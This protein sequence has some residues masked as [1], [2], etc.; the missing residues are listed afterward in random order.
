VTP[1]LIPALT[2][3]CLALLVWGTTKPGRVYEF[4]FLTGAVMA[5]W[6]LPQIFGLAGNAFLPVDALAKTVLFM[7]LC[8]GACYFGYVW[9]SKRKFPLDFHYDQAAL[10]RVCAGLTLFGGSFYFAVSRLPE[11]Q[12]AMTQFSGLSVA[13]LF[14][15]D[16]LAYGFAIALLLFFRD[17]SRLALALA[18]FASSFYLERI[19]FGGRRGDVVQVVLMVLLAIWFQRGKVMPIPLMIVAMLGGSLVFNSIDQYRAIATSKDGQDWKKIT[20]IDFLGNLK[21]LSAH[22]GE[23]MTNVVYNI[24]AKD[25]EMDLDFGAFNWNMLVFNYVPAQIVGQDF[26]AFLMFDIGDAAADRYGY[27]ANVGATA[28]GFSDA[29]ASF[30]YFGFMKFFLIA[31]LIAIVYRSAVRGNFTAQ[32]CYM[33]I[34]PDALH[35][36]THHTQWFF[37]PWLHMAIFLLPALLVA[38]ASPGAPVRLRL[39]EQAPPIAP[40]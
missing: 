38:R 5:G 1:V 8:I 22:G 33:V 14:F 30:W 6:V 39:A 26:K 2:V 20:Q 37:S 18:L 27:E 15:A 35:A 16:V 36:V 9:Q 12:L 34:L 10:L 29:F 13:Y 7:I 11:E 3:L 21:Q 32:I 17:R 4:P 25:A 40:G 19:V 31:Y 28:T 23:E 24:A